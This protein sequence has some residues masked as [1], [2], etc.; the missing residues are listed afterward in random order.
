[1]KMT[2]ASLVLNLS[3]RAYSF[4]RGVVM[5]CETRSEK[6]DDKFADGYVMKNESN[7]AEISCTEKFVQHWIARGFRVVERRP[8]RVL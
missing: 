7:G 3:I 2:F 4:L 5:V 8:I 1:M 6:D